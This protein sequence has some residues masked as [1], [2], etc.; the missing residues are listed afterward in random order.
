MCN[1]LLNIMDADIRKNS[2][3]MISKINFTKTR[4]MRNNFL[5]TLKNSS[6]SFKSLYSF[7]FL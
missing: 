1:E 2:V 6:I 7:I 3:L 4:Q 5:M